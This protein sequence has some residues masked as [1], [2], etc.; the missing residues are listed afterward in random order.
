MKKTLAAIAILVC[1]LTGMLG[2]LAETADAPKGSE[3]FGDGK[4]L[5]LACLEGWYS[6][7]TV[8]DN[9]PAWQKIEEN[10]G[11]KIEWE[12][13]SDYNTAMQPRVAAGQEL[14]DIM[15]IP[16]SM[17]NSGVYKM[18][19]DGT[20]IPL[21]ELIR[22]HAPNIQRVL[23]ENPVLKGLMTAP[24][25]H[26]YSICDTTMFVNDLVVQNA[27]FIREDWLEA[28]DLEAPE[29]IEDWYNVLTAFKEYDPTGYG[30]QVVPYGRN[31]GSLYGMVNAFTG[32]YGLPVGTSYWW[33]DEEG[34]VFLTYASE[35]FRAFLTEMAKWYAEGLIDM[36]IRDESNFQSLVSTNVVGAFSTLSER[37]PQYDGLLSTAGVEGN[38]ILLAPPMNGDK[39]LIKRDTTWNHYGITKYCEDPVLAIRWL[40]YVWGSEE[41]VT[42]NEWGIEGLTFEYDE[43]G[44]KYFTDF[45]LNNPDGLD[46]YNAL[47]SL[48][49][50][51]TILVRTPA[52]VYAALNPEYVIEYGEMLRDQRSEPFPQ[53]MATEEEQATI[54]RI[55]PDLLTYCD[56]CVD[57]FIS[58]IMPMEEFDAF[59]EKLY[60]IGLDELLA[61]KQAQF[62]RSGVR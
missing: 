62:D 33:Y 43:D 26:I 4:T 56:E 14:P 53:V 47:R 40:D 42:I 32:A 7:V 20:I 57:K 36:E 46:P 37:V 35:E 50:S 48:G 59:V 55:Q 34:N 25:G 23:D 28:L 22:E 6:A 13:S 2:A 38:H 5:S 24:D 45:V 44:N 12:A 1:M 15:L 52:E 41:G 8:N 30:A 51:N 18:A 21:D 58:G 3:P 49:S 17:Q 10:T 61:V 27:M 39:L 19:L 54:D 9:L 16:P 29:T 31:A 11:V 60:E